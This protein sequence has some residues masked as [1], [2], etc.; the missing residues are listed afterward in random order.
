MSYRTPY[1]KFFFLFDSTPVQSTN[2]SNPTVIDR[3]PGA[4]NKENI[5]KQLRPKTTLSPSW[6]FDAALLSSPMTLSA[7]VDLSVH[8]PAAVLNEVGTPALDCGGD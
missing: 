2:P 4:A 8:S 6:M 1:N 7:L 3:E 5:P